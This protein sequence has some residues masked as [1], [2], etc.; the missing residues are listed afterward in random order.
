[1]PTETIP[2]T[3]IIHGHDFSK[4]ND[5]DSIMAAMI[6]SGF[7]ATA[8]G[9]AIEE[10][11]RMVGPDATWLQRLAGAP[12]RVMPCIFL[13]DRLVADCSVGAAAAQKHAETEETMA[14]L[15]H[16]LLHKLGLPLPQCVVMLQSTARLAA[17]CTCH[18]MLACVT[19]GL[20]DAF[21]LQINWRLEDDP[22]TANTDPAHTDPAFRA[23]CRT[24]LYLG[25]TSNLISA[26]VREQ[27][28]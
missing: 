1:M 21:V 24:K 12:E 25:Y 4:G 15:L 20:A 8:L 3:P 11:N 14:E 10:V 5:L 17:V 19:A 9:Q 13:G 23:S 2:D 18:T 7:Q 27:I 16:H 26:G 22:I 6:T 28:R